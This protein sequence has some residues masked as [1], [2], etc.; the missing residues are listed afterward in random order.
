MSLFWKCRDDKRGGGGLCTLSQGSP[1]HKSFEGQVE[2]PCL[3]A[4]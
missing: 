2:V 4:G 1:N 3:Q